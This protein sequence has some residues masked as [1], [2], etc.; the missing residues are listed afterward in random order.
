MIDPK[1]ELLKL[2]NLGPKTVPHLVEIGI[3]SRND[4]V[5]IGTEEVF[6][7]IYFRY[8]DESRLS[9]NYLYAL[10]GAIE[11]CDWRWISAERKLELKSFFSSI[12]Q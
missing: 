7:R 3:L 1:V 2:K 9:L 4:L 8:R 5:A 12:K 6:R 11:D 10:E